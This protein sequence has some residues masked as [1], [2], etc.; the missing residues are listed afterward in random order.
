MLNGLLAGIAAY[1]K[2]LRLINRLRLWGY[3][4]APGLISLLLGFGIFGSAWGISDDIGRRL[5]ALY[6]F[7]WGRDFLEGLANIIG[8]LFVVA[9]GLVLFKHLVLA[10]ASPFM[11]YFSE[12]IEREITGRAEEVSFSLSRLVGDLLR[13][14]RIALRNIIREL[15]FTLILL[16]LGL[17]PVL[18]PFT[19][20]GIFIL[21]SYYAG[22]G[23]LDYLMERHFT[24]RQSVRFVRRNAGLAIGNG[25]V[26][27]LLLFSIVGFLFALPLATA[28]ATVEGSRRLEKS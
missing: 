20:L 17:I 27:L 14:I 5:I 11:S 15:L 2:A 23:N 28:A 21:Q 22:F 7:E 9:L 13:G 16:F 24:V 6:P 18:S 25:A 3:I 4:L 12:K 1:G 19:T 8:A 10:L 26:F